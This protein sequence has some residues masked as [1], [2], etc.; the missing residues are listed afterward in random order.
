MS[1]KSV[2]ANDPVSHQ[3]QSYGL[4]SSFCLLKFIFAFCS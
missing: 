2:C 3:T 1:L 4:A